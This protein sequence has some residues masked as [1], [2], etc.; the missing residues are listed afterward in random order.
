MP[1]FHGQG[2]A[3]ALPK[4][5]EIDAKHDKQPG[6]PGMTQGQRMT[7]LGQGIEQ[8]TSDE[9]HAKQQHGFVDHA[10]QAS[11][12]VRRFGIQ[13]RTILPGQVRGRLPLAA[14]VPVP[15]LLLL[16]APP[17][18]LGLGLELGRQPGLSYAATPIAE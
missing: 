9:Q 3:A 7:A 12:Q 10:G 2:L 1:G 17:S 16:S 8:I 14:L 15:E 4:E 11:I 5:T 6:L 18:E 13:G